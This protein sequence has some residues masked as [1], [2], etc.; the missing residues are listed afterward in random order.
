[1]SN[2]PVE[3][4]PNRV[5][6]R[7]ERI[8]RR[9]LQHYDITYGW[10]LTDRTMTWS[11]FERGGWSTAQQHIRMDD[12]DYYV[13]VQMEVTKSVRQGATKDEM[14][15]FY[16]DPSLYRAELHVM[17]MLKEF[18]DGSP[19]PDARRGAVFIENDARR[20]C[21]KLKRYLQRKTDVCPE[22][23]RRGGS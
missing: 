8:L 16:R 2:A 9:A 15:A 21:N 4:A 18:P 7:L 12:I 19:H 10:F 13:T 20:M 1:M 5:T 23:R 17:E 3:L 6:R 14:V 11:V 22:G